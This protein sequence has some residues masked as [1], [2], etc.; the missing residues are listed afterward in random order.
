MRD[1]ALPACIEPDHPGLA[2]L[3]ADVPPD[4]P[5]VAA[6]AVTRRLGPLH[7]RRG[8]GRRPIADVLGDRSANC[9]D[10]TLVLVSALRRLGVPAAGL[11]GLV[12]GTAPVCVH[13]VG[14][15]AERGTWHVLD[16]D[17]AEP[18]RLDD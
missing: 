4:S 3:C 13:A 16:V 18:A 8:V 7:R 9:M 14:L 10:Y 6:L 11:I 12:K 2:A 17:R 1:G 5:V 15:V